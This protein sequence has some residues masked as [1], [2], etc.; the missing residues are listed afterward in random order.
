MEVSVTRGRL[1]G[2]SPK[3]GNCKRKEKAYFLGDSHESVNKPKPHKR[4][5]PVYAYPTCSD[6]HIQAFFYGFG[7]ADNLL[8]LTCEWQV[9]GYAYIYS[10]FSKIRKIKRELLESVKSRSSTKEVCPYMP[11]LALLGQ[12]HMDILL[13]LRR[14]GQPFAAHM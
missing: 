7:G 9:V 3:L 2:K 14:Y 10:A 4:S 11:I 8:R 12:T 1:N 5:M 13:L 6:R